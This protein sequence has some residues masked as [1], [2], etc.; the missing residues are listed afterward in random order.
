MVGVE[1]QYI[2]GAFRGDLVVAN[3]LDVANLEV[4]LGSQFLLY[5]SPD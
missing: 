1:A 2:A 3:V 5:R 4:Q